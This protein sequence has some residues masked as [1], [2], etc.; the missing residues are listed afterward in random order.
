[1]EILQMIEEWHKGC[2]CAGEIHDKLYDL[3]PNT[4]HP[5]QCVECTI[6]LIH[7]I[8]RKERIELYNGCITPKFEDVIKRLQATV[9]NK[10]TVTRSDIDALLRE[11]HRLNK[12]LQRKGTPND[13][14]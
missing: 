11:Y 8:E 7:A 2:S 12:I 6:A 10:G 14:S 9:K 1:M 13:N 3:P 5:S 4:T